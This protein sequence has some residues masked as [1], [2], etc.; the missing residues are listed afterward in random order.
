[1]ADTVLFAQISRDV[2]T[3][4]LSYFTTSSA[5]TQCV[6]VFTLQVLWNLY[7]LIHLHLM[8]QGSESETTK[9]AFKVLEK[10]ARKRYEKAQNFLLGSNSENFPR[11]S[12]VKS[13]FSPST[14]SFPD[15]SK[16]QES[17]DEIDNDE[18][19]PRR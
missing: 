12:S 5:S 3:K 14:F 19:L 17:V 18:K 16:R 10:Y 11:L 15:A 1:M 7:L 4:R 13:F 2:H 6:I 9:E 8:D